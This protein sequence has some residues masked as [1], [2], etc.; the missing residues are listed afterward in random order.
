MKQIM[1]GLVLVCS[2]T[3][4]LNA[5]NPGY[6]GKLLFIRPEISYAPALSHPTANN[7]GSNTYGN[8]GNR[9]GFNTK[10]GV[11][12][13]YAIART[14]V[15]SVEGNYLATGLIVDASTPSAIFAQGFDTHYLFYKLRGPE[16]GLAW[17]IFDHYNGGLAP[18]GV[19]V[20]F[21]LRM[22]FLSGTVLD[23]RTTYFGSDAALGHLPIGI[24]P[25]YNHLTFGLEIGRHTI[26]LDRIVL[27]LSLELNATPSTLA[28]AYFGNRSVTGNQAAFQEAARYRMSTHTLVMFK[29]GVGYIF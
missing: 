18:L 17:H 1:C 8:L 23:K 9:L 14:N 16:L 25:N 2:L 29:T 4:A 28:Y 11:Q 15:L 19:Y 6:M 7:R 12:I 13:G 27:G 26:I 22:A 3:I 21:R 10:Y 20:S 5:Q 24:Q